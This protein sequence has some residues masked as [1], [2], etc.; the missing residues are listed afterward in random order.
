MATVTTTVPTATAQANARLSQTRSTK[1]MIGNIVTYVL[2]LLGGV[3]ILVPFLWMISTSLKTP[4]QLF[5]YPIKWIPDPAVPQNYVDVWTTLQGMNPQLN[6]IQVFANS[7][8]ITMLA[9]IGEIASA[10]LVAYGF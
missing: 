8:F 1:K 9:M 5:T 10:A 7:I 4:D 6:F 3:I 2:L